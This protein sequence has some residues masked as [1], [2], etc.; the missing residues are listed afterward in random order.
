MVITLLE[1]AT[2]YWVK[3]LAEPDG[4]G[5]RVAEQEPIPTGCPLTSVCLLWYMHIHTHKN[6]N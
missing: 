4:P 2:A 5:P 6:S 3:V 1:L